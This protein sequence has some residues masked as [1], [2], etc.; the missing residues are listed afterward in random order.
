MKNTT[1]N[2]VLG[3]LRKKYEGQRA[4]SGQKMSAFRC[5]VGTV[6]STRTRD[7]RTAEATRN[8]F[9][10]YST[11]EKLSKAEEK[12]VEKLIKPVG[13]YRVK[14][15]TV[16]KLAQTLVKEYN[17]R[18]PESMEELLELPG[19]GR[20]V[21]GCVLNYAFL[22][23]AI[24]VDSHVAIV[25]KRLGWTEEKKPEKIEVDLMKLIPRENWIEVNNLLV[26]HGQQ[27]CFTRKPNCKACPLTRECRYYNEVV[28]Q[29]KSSSRN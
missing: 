24:P 22:K 11:P 28:K 12:K 5:L 17:G 16:K 13:F 18:V 23:P 9:K 29:E 6:L 27:T 10:F 20:K 3:K 1:T 19:V 2:L 8:L 7:E 14:A 4:F 25:S 21:A 15:R 26:L